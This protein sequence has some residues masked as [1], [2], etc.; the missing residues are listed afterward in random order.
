MKNDI[1]SMRPLN[2]ART[3]AAWLCLYAALAGAEVQA[4]RNVRDGVVMDGVPA[5]SLQI[6]AGVERYRGGSEARLLDWS[7]DG[8]LLVAAREG[9]LDQMLR[10]RAGP[11]PQQRIGAPMSSLHAA[12][13]Q[14]FRNDRVAFLASEADAER[15]GG[16]ALMLAA[17]DSGDTRQLVGATAQPGAAVWAHDGRQLAFSARLRDAQSADLYVLDTSGTAEPRLVATGGYGANH[18]PETAAQ[19]LALEGTE[20]YQ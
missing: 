12:A 10:L 17:L 7:S 1:K 5:I 6:A 9:G 16:A 8:A 18:D 2:G 20:I 11:T 4:A 19:H 13:L 15:S 3:R 14:P